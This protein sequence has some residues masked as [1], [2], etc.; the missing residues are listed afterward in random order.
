MNITN[1]ATPNIEH[2]SLEN[3]NMIIGSTNE[4][5]SRD[6]INAFHKIVSSVPFYSVCPVS[7]TVPS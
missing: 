6:D 5:A 3:S 7:I 2:R 1:K 4:G